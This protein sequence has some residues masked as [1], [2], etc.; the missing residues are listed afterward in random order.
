MNKIKFLSEL[1]EELYDHDISAKSIDEIV[2][3]YEGI[4]DEAINSGEVEDEIITR[5]GL[6][7]SIAEKLAVFEDENNGIKG[8]MIATTPFIA[9]IIFFILGMQLDLWHP[10][11]MVFFIVPIAGVMLG[12]R[13]NFRTQ[14]VA[15]SPF[16][17]TIFYL[18]YG[19]NTGVW[20][21]T[22]VV[23]FIIVVLGLLFE[24][25]GAK[26]IIGASMFTIIPIVYL[27]ME[28]NNPSIYNLLVFIVLIAIGLYLG[29]IKLSFGEDNIINR[30]AT[31]AFVVM[32]IIYVILGLT[33][34]W[35]HP[36]W[37]MFLTIP[38]FVMYRVE[39][40][41]PLV[42][43]TPFLSVFVFIILGELFDIYEWAWLVFLVIPLVGIFTE[44]KDEEDIF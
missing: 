21:P 28:L 12:A 14:L 44:D 17:A 4:I 30:N 7:H 15:L 23:F 35:W 9:T 32:G 39:E 16:V 37:L 42:A 41:I 27:W 36:T 11:W 43:Y 10:G 13:F 33:L 26:R 24:E 3:D 19:F 8:K 5:L 22:W 34:N 2:E 1:K 38:M 40:K 29:V 6:P 25:T 31:I 20:H 18:I